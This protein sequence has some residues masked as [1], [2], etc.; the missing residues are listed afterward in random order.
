MPVAQ[1]PGRLSSAKTDVS[2]V[3]D[4]VVTAASTADGVGTGEAGVRPRD[5][6]LLHKK[7]RLG[8]KADGVEVGDASAPGRVVAYRQRCDREALYGKGRL[9]GEGGLQGRRFGRGGRAAAGA[10][11]RHGLGHGGPGEANDGEDGKKASNLFHLKISRG[12]ID[13]EKTFGQ[14]KASA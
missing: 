9:D 11:R 3:D 1:Q 8:P 4:G 13:L 5:A 2:S 6:P 14:N 12:D 10:A 7:G